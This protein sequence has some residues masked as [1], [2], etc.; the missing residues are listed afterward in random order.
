MMKSGLVLVFALSALP[1][2][3]MDGCSPSKMT[4]SSAPVEVREQA[5]D[6]KAT[7]V[8]EEMRAAAVRTAAAQPEAEK[9]IQ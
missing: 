2:W 4:I 5:A 9:K 8:T 3:A 7:K 1:A 6:A